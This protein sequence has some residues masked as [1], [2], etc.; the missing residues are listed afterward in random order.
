MIAMKSYRESSNAS[1]AEPITLNLIGMP[2]RGTYVVKE[3]IEKAPDHNHPC[4]ITT[5]AVRISFPEMRSKLFVNL[6]GYKGSNMITLRRC[7]GRCSNS[8]SPMTCGPTKIKEKKVKM[9]VSSYLTG[10]TPREQLKELVLDDHLECGCECTPGIARDC[11][12]MFNTRTCECSC[13]STK[14][15]EK[16]MICEMIKD[17][18][19]DMEKCKCKSKSVATRGVEDVR[20]DCNMALDLLKNKESSVSN[21]IPWALL[22][23][24]ITLAS[25]L[26]M[27]T[28]YYR[29]RASKIKKIVK[30][31]KAIKF[32][33]IFQDD[34]RKISDEIV[35]LHSH[36]S[37]SLTGTLERYK[38][39][40]NFQGMPG[41]QHIPVGGEFFFRGL[42]ADSQ[43]LG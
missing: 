33:G 15:G 40:E 3:D 17:Q 37:V 39:S 5:T 30:Q 10:E 34:P 23:S 43:Y 35:S 41:T 1:E 16:K 36:P 4:K 28:C 29:K 6:L 26:F 8:S 12:G 38:S 2:K 20:Y 27:S 21:M 42:Q 9:T 19:W 11:A 24:S 13:P 18:Y 25:I 22:G 7:R 31:T 32:P 14:F